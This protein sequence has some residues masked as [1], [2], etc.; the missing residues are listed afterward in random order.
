VTGIVIRDDRVLP[1]R[2]DTDGPRT[3]SL[4]GDKAENGETL[5]QA[6]VCRFQRPDPGAEA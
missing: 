3:W 4:P 5:E 1:L 2:Q 6:L